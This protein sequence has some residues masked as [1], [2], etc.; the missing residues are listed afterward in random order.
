VNPSRQQYPAVPAS[1]VRMV[2]AEVECFHLALAY[3]QHSQK[4]MRQRSLDFINPHPSAKT[5]SHQ[6]V[7]SRRIKVCEVLALAYATASRYRMQL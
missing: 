5:S 6:G 1:E 7:R 4:G 2:T 3:A